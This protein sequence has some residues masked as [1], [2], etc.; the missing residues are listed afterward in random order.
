MSGL[1]LKGCWPNMLAIHDS[2]GWALNLLTSMAI[3]QIGI[4]F[5]EL[6]WWRMI[7]SLSVGLPEACTGPTFTAAR[8]K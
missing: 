5:T 6:D 8:G 4:G 7:R 3:G 2:A 1:E